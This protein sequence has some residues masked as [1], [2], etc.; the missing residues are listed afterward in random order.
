MQLSQA[1]LALLAGVTIAQIHPSFVPS[2]TFFLTLTPRCQFE[3]IVFDPTGS[4]FEAQGSLC[5]YAREADV[6]YF[7]P[8][9]EP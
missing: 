3:D 4:K 7:C 6:M 1:P 5:A 9:G 2:P 8:A